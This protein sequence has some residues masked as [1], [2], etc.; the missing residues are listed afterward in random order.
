M[1]F[2]GLS[3]CWGE[4]ED[5]DEDE[6]VE[7]GTLPPTVSHVVPESQ[8][9]ELGPT[10]SVLRQTGGTVDMV[11]RFGHMHTMI[12]S[13]EEPLVGTVIDDGHSSALVPDTRESQAAMGSFGAG[14]SRQHTQ[15]GDHV[16]SSVA[17]SQSAD[18][19]ETQMLDAVERDWQVQWCFLFCQMVQRLMWHTL[20]GDVGSPG[21]WF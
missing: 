20:L 9:E 7:W 13:D 5:I 18:D 1:R 4:I 11:R 8:G 14:F 3:L 15:Q 10:P 21:D 6:D 19:D 12:D 16:V 17:P 2:S